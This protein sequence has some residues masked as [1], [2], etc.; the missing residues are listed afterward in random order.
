MCVCGGGG[1]G[2]PYPGS[3][4]ITLISCHNQELWVEMLTLQKKLKDTMK[5]IVNR[6]VYIKIG[7]QFV[8]WSHILSRTILVKILIV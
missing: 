5:S 2:K 7:N 3:G 6:A 4:L 1:G 8:L